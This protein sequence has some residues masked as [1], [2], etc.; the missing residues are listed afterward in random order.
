MKIKMYKNKQYD[1]SRLAP[2]LEAIIEKSVIRDGVAVTINFR[3]EG[4]SAESGGYHP[5]EIR[6]ESD[7]TISYITDFCYFGQDFCKE[8]DFDFSRGVFCHLYTGES[9]IDQGAE[10]FKL[11][12]DNFIGYY[13]S[14]VYSVSVT[15]D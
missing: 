2:M 15:T 1:F 11:W 8:I 6:I 13:K 5:V 3:D 14:G 9:P 10:L 4:Y 12:C 7:G